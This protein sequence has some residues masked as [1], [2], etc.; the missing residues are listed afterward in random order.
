M[1]LDTFSRI[2]TDLQANILT[3]EQRLELAVLGARTV[4]DAVA[5]IERQIVEASEA[6]DDRGVTMLQERLGIVS[7]LC[8][9]YGS[10]QVSNLPG[11]VLGM[12]PVG[13]SVHQIQLSA[14]LLLH[15]SLEKLQ[16]V[17]MH[18]RRHTNQVELKTAR[19]DVVLI[20]GNKKVTDTT[21]MLEGD[22]E[23]HT[24]ARFGVRDD[25]PDAIYGEGARLF[26]DLSAHRSRLDAVMTQTGDIEGL[27]SDIWEEDLR[28]HKLDFANLQKQS[29]ETGY[30]VS[31]GVVSVQ[32][33]N[34]VVL[35]E[36]GK[37]DMEE[38][39]KQ[40]AELNTEENPQ[41]IM[42]QIYAQMAVTREQLEGSV[43]RN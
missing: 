21:V 4:G 17:C 8:C 2:E 6:G 19:E 13:G 43:E 10:V 16:E 27:Q 36:E 18:E 26:E 25:R 33:K 14:D 39:E 34:W 7:A 1:Q 15:D 9:E 29:Q 37:A 38:V 5:N 28:N 24:E 23:K 20:V 11:G 32:V 40:V 41:A 22:T 30:T 3:G 31:R 42:A 12:A 35:L